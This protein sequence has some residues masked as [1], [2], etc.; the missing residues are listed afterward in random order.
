VEWGLALS[1]LEQGLKLWNTKESRKYL[2]RVIKLKKEWYEEFNR[3]DRSQLA[4]DTIQRELRIIAESFA[5][6][7]GQNGHSDS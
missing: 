3:T 1:V 7:L 4:L 5:N 6:N 2:D